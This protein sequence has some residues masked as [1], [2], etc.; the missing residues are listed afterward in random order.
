MQKEKENEKKKEKERKNKP[1]KEKGRKMKSEKKIEVDVIFK[2]N[3]PKGI[4]T[5]IPNSAK[6]TKR[7]K[8]FIFKGFIFL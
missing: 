2:S 3:L 4:S 7:R 1:E 8:P 5:K 6:G